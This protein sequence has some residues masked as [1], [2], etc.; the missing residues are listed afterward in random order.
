MKTN[1]RLFIIIILLLFSFGCA[2]GTKDGIF[3]AIYEGSV[4][5]NEPGHYE[6]DPADN[7]NREKKSYNDYK[8]EREKE[9][10]G[11]Q[12]TKDQ[13]D[14]FKKQDIPA[15]ST[16]EEATDDVTVSKGINDETI[17]PPG[18]VTVEDD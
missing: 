1:Y 7:I 4:R 11:D 14:F 16:K 9:L 12:I 15:E 8:R 3:G 13:M 5:S 17:S 10:K 6:D 2:E 18:N